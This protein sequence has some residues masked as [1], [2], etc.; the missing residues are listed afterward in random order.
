MY[1]N[2][3]SFRKFRAIINTIVP[4]ALDVFLIY[5]RYAL[6][7]LIHRLHIVPKIL[8]QTV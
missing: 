3:D 7:N 1:E 4:N 6:S 2:G 8:F 5:V